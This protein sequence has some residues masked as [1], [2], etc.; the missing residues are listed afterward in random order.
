MEYRESD[1]GVLP[2][3]ARG[4]YLRTLSGYLIEKFGPRRMVLIGL[5]VQGSGLVLF[6]RIHNLWEFYLAFL[7]M[8][9][10]VGLAPGFPS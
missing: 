7:I 10:G 2:Y 1:L 3:S 6:S 4:D 5:L 9:L 8:N